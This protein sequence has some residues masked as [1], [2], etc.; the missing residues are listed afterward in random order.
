MQDILFPYFYKFQVH[1]EILKHIYQ[2]PHF[3]RVS[4][5][6][7]KKLIWTIVTEGLPKIFSAIHPQEICDAAYP[8]LFFSKRK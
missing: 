3:S 4:D 8:G 7:L 1:L 2:L 5:P 6:R